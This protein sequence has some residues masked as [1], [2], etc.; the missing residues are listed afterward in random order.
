MLTVEKSRWCPLNFS[1]PGPKPV[2][3]AS[4]QRARNVPL[5]SA[6]VRGGGVAYVA[7]GRVTKSFIPA[8]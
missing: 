2:G 8:V 6:D 1:G 7:A 5:A 3:D 4:K